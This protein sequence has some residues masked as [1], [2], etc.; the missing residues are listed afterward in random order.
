MVRKEKAGEFILEAAAH[1]AQEGGVDALTFADIASAAEI[2]EAD[3]LAAFPTMD[4]LVKELA[5]RIYGA[6]VGKVEEHIGDDE[7][8]GA[9]SRAYVRASNATN[10]EERFSDIAAVLLQSVVY[11]PELLEIVRRNQGDIHAA[12]LADR[13]D[14]VTASVIRL[15]VDG[16]WMN[17]MFKI[18]AVPEELEAAVIERLVALA[19]P[20]RSGSETV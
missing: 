2:D 12:M 20:G 6:F 4:L 17:R 13:I 8:P 15:A 16:M 3:V 14:P 1:L 10:E 18:Q 19:A 9:W 11:K 5:A 7:E